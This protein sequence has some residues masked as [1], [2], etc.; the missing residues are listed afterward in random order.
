MIA[1]IASII[2]F[3]TLV[4]WVVIFCSSNQDYWY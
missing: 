3:A 2:V 1:V 4:V